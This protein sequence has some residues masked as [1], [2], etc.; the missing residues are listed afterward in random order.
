MARKV[1][2]VL[3]FCYATWQGITCFNALTQGQGFAQIF[4]AILAIAG[5]I[6]L[7]RKQSKPAV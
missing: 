2:A 7:W 5:G 3:L 6:Y 4:W 1:I